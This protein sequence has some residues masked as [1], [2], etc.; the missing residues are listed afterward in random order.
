MV[1]EQNR[2]RILGYQYSCFISSTISVMIAPSSAAAV[3]SH[4]QTLLCVSSHYLLGTP[5][6]PEYCCFR[7]AYNSS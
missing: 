1:I 5:S 2:V 3:F 7:F 4:L 6:E